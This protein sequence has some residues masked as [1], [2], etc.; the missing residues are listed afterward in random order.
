MTFELTKSVIDDIIF[1]MED[2]NSEFVFDAEGS[3]VVPLDSFLQ[4]EAEELEENENI[5]PLPRWTSDDGF[6]IMEEFVE[7]LRIPSVKEELEQILANGRG[8]FRNY[9]NV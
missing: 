3:C 4:T 7:V 6:K 2:Q 9:K 8:V 5:Y 1:S